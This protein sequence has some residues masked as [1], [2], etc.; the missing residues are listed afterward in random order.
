MSVKTGQA[1]FQE[2]GP[3][4]HAAIALDSPTVKYLRALWSKVDGADLD[5]NARET[6]TYLRRRGVVPSAVALDPRVAAALQDL[7]A[8]E[9]V[10]HLAAS[11]GLSPSRLRALVHDLTGMP[12]SR[13]RLWQR[14]RIAMLSLPDKPI[15]LAAA[16]A[17]FADQAHLTRTATRLLGQTPGQLARMLRSPEPNATT[18]AK[19]PVAN[20][21]CRGVRVVSRRNTQCAG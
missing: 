11:V 10:D 8:A 3:G 13:L 9:F 6:M 18:T 1:Q 2:L 17:G 16:D 4:R 20:T 5:T 15:A 7:P 14:L 21:V 19:P 12:P